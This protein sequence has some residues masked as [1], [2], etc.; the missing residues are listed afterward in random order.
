MTTTTTR[1]V[2][3]GKKESKQ[4]KTKPEDAQDFSG[5]MHM[6]PTLMAHRDDDYEHS[7]HLQLR[8]NIKFPVENQKNYLEQFLDEGSATIE[9]KT[10]KFIHESKLKIQN[11]DSDEE[12][13]AGAKNCFADEIEEIEEL[14]DD[15]HCDSDSVSDTSS[16]SSND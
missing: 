16:S 14:S 1:L 6:S 9:E 2:K 11:Y 5:C 10:A 8:K 4:S 12:E 15:L 13:E 7:L 3:Q